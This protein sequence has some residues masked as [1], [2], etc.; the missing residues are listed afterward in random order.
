MLASQTGRRAP[1]ILCLVVVAT[2]VL[3][4]MGWYFKL[5]RLKSVLPGLA[6]VKPNTALGFI[7][8]GFA[9]Y[10]LSGNRGILKRDLFHVFTHL[11][12]KLS[13]LFCLLTAS[14]L[15]GLTLTEYFFH[16]DFGIDEL[17]F[18]DP[19]STLFPG[20]MSPITAA[21][22]LILCVAILCAATQS[23]WKLICSQITTL[24]VMLTSFISLLGY[25]NDLPSLYKIFIYS[26]IA[27]PTTL[28]FILL[29]IA[30]LW[31]QDDF[32]IAALLSGR[33]P[34]S[35]IARRLL[36]AI[37]LI[38]LTLIS[39]GY[40]ATKLGY[41]DLRFVPVT[42][43]TVSVTLLSFL[44]LWNAN[45]VNRIDLIRSLAIDKLSKRERQLSQSQKF[46]H[47][48]DWEWNPNSKQFDLS[49][50]MFE[51]LGIQERS[52]FGLKE[53]LKSI[54]RHDRK[55]LKRYL[56]SKMPEQQINSLEIR[57]VR[58][59][60]TVRTLQINGTISYGKEGRIDA[61]LGSALDITDRKR[62]EVDIRTLA[63]RLRLIVEHSP[64]GVALF[65]KNMR[66]LIA[67]RRW[68]KDYQ[69]EG[70]NYIGRSHYDLIEVSERW[71]AIHQRCLEGA[72]ESSNE[73][74]ITRPN[75]TVQWIRWEGR[76]WHDQNG[77]VGGIIIFSED[78][79]QRKRA[80]LALVRAN[81]E[82]ES[83]VKER[84]GYLDILQKI[85]R[86]ANEAKD[87]ESVIQFCLEEVCKFAY[88]QVGHA[89][90]I[91]STVG[92][93]FISTHFWYFS[94]PKRFE[95]FKLATDQL[96]LKNPKSLLKAVF[97]SHQVIWLPNIDSNPDFQRADAAKK[98]GL[99]AGIALPVIVEREVVGILEFFSNRTQLPDTSFIDIMLQIG[100][101]VGRVFERA[102][103]EKNLKMKA[104]DLER[105]N[106]ELEQFAYI[107]SHDLR[108]PLRVISNYCQ[109]L[110][111]K[112]GDRLDQNATK[113]MNYIIEGV[114]RMQTLIADLLA[115]SRIGRTDLEVES[116]DFNDALQK[117]LQNLRVSILEHKAEIKSDKLPV[118][119]ANRT[120]IIQVFQNLIGNAI[121]FHGQ[122][123]PQITITAQ[124]GHSEWLFSVKDNGIGIEQK[125]ADRIF[126]IFQRL[127][128]REEF[129]GTGIGLSICKKV[130][131]K[132]GGRIWVKSQ[133]GSGST[134]Y[135]TLPNQLTADFRAKVVDQSNAIDP[136]RSANG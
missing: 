99:L 23:R 64:S 74:Y 100:F 78:I 40:L 97:D 36:P 50:E 60:G 7:A 131:E 93:E 38:E 89:F 80:E 61:L 63:Y 122:A 75:N 3:V 84:T 72:I 13:F 108:E 29:S 107:A 18:K 58:P 37:A 24:L 49:E 30:L 105:S 104:L 76:P 19:Q 53:M 132:W 71:K 102:R 125:Y 43:V 52:F 123:P 82:L 65:D 20:R 129:P 9:V 66:Y 11:R 33:G 120:Q 25:L 136:R 22:F 42:I 85:S 98:C 114:G 67:S 44:T 90:K 113:Y 28:A 96:R 51:I 103:T 4:L 119:R 95:P 1:K 59:S 46:A 55:L 116:L 83:K 14:T 118:L 8:L 62:M 68:V 15:A 126:V 112:Y 54:K 109:L 12:V 47:L 77:A 56:N 31:A 34:G 111:K 87:F 57:I 86:A 106:Q 88:W 130:I 48:G 16:F 69:L 127:H 79:T 17:L 39:L 10:L 133:P 115:Y 27:L 2:G 26:S 101:Q 81:A 128:T 134:F 6:T 92:I 110:E 5:T 117:A 124:E 35:V 94:D 73:D 21:N 91:E 41:Y 45:L 121:K 32:G 70:Y 135:F